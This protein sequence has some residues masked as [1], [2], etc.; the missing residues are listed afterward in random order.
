MKQTTDLYNQIINRID[1]EGF[2]ENR[3]SVQTVHTFGHLMRFNFGDGY[4]LM[5][6]RKMFLKG[7]FRE[8]K[9]M[10]LGRT[11]VQ[12]LQEGGVT[13]WDRWADEEGQL[14]PVY[15]AMWRRW[16]GLNGELID[17]LQNLILDLKTNAKSRR[18]II[19][20]WNPALLP[21]EVNKTFTENVADGKQA[22]PP[23]HCFFQVDARK[24]SKQD[25]AKLERQRRKRFDALNVEYRLID[26]AAAKAFR[27]EDMKKMEVLIER[28]KRV[29][30]LIAQ[31]SKLDELGNRVFVTPTLDELPEYALSLLLYMRS[32][33]TPLGMPTNIAGYAA[34]LQLIA[35]ECGMLPDDYIHVTGNTHIYQNQVEQIKEQVTR[36][37]FDRPILNIDFNFEHDPKNLDPSKF[38]YNFVDG[39]DF[40]VFGYEHHPAIKFEQAAL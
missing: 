11:D 4:P 7:V 36:Q 28:K 34:L 19:S 6:T 13:F 22:L 38:F 10:L 3:T 5:T 20:S 1:T 2:G 16:P 24:T 8:L 30:S 40:D 18:H 23:C 29:D 17:Q 26:E 37:P 25:L 33:D 35:M 12:Y 15:G 21:D 31:V 9:W 14:G 39:I 27:D 32:N